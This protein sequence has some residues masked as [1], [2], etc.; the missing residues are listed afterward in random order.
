[1]YFLEGGVTLSPEGSSTQVRAGEVVVI[2][3]GV[4]SAW[5][6]EQTVRKIYCILG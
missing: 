1:M 3:A 2:P 4:A 6:S 5:H